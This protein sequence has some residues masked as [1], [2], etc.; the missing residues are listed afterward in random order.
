[1][2]RSLR[3]RLPAWRVSILLTHQ[4]T[5]SFLQILLTVYLSRQLDPQVYG[6]FAISMVAIVLAETLREFGFSLTRIQDDDTSDTFH[7]DFWV[8]T[9]RG[10]L[11]SFIVCLSAIAQLF[12]AP[13]LIAKPITINLIF[14]SMIPWISGMNAAYTIKIWKNGKIRLFIYADF[15]AFIFSLMIIPFFLSW[16][17]KTLVLPGQLVTYQIFIFVFRIFL[18]RVIP[19]KVRISHVRE[20]FLPRSYNLGITGILKYISSNL[21]SMIIAVTLNSTGLGLY[22]R[23]YQLTFVPIQQVLDSQTN[24]VLSSKGK[25]NRIRS[26]ESVHDK[27]APGLIFA[28]TFISVNSSS[29]VQ[30]LYGENW[31]KASVP[32]TILS[33]GG[34]LRVI[35]YKLQWHL[36]AM[37]NHKFLL[38]GSLFLEVSTIF[39]ILVGSIWG[40]GGIA[41]G[42]VIPLFLSCL[43]ESYLLVKNALPVRKISYI[44]GFMMLTISFILHLVMLSFFNDYFNAHLHNVAFRLGSA[45]L[46]F[47][48]SIILIRRAQP[49]YSSY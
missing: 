35:E 9:L 17:L 10:A 46:I 27:L 11:L 20:S 12:F 18:M 37:S 43:F 45:L 5:K 26:I 6:Y 8:L 38:V 40:I 19:R 13:Q 21:D 33:V 32:L 44:S 23:A 4:L 25:S 42:I 47:V 7:T 3:E 14:L 29:V 1:M 41:M 30:F 2:R 48:G 36:L 24:S 31:E 16:N 22:N 28:F 34:A 15:F 39:G 49:S